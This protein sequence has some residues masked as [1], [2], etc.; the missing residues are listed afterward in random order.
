MKHEEIKLIKTPQ[1]KQLD[2][3]IN[4]IQ[5]L[6]EGKT[7]KI[8]QIELYNLTIYFKDNYTKSE[9]LLYDMRRSSEQKEDYIKKMNH[10]NYTYSQIKNI[11]GVKKDKFRTFLD[12]KIII[13]IISEKILKKDGK[14]KSTPK[15][16]INTLFKIN[17]NIKIYLLDSILSEK[18]TPIIFIKLLSFLG[19]KSY[20]ILPYILFYYRHVSTFYIDGYIFINFINK[21][22]TLF[23]FES[24]INE[25]N[26]NNEL[27]FENK[28]L[29]EMNI[30]SMI[31]I[32]NN[33]EINYEN[34]VQPN[35]E[36]FEVKVIE[37]QYKKAFYKNI[38]CS[39]KSIL[40]NKNKI[41]E[42]CDWLRNEVLKGHSIYI[43]IDNYENNN[44]TGDESNNNNI[45]NNWI[46]V[47]IVFLTYIVKVNYLE[48][49]NY[50]KEKINYIQNIS[51]IIDFY[52]REID[53]N[54]FFSD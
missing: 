5:N 20:E 27:S 22:K 8:S 40:K 1:E 53:F 32:D 7:K 38:Y 41:K 51:E 19:E 31:S 11:S 23:S 2:L 15:D 26:K 13:F 34:N 44:E 10:I 48:I 25:L 36:N 14:N 39:K 50:L 45:K 49:V 21:N 4:G 12:N 43:N 47:V 3:I 54:D 33:D 17:D 46:F 6:Y 42:I 52:L 30:T 16:I 24:L 29:K 35:Q 37:N 9:Y 28:F 18:E